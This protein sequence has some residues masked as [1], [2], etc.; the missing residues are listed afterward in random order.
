MST[1]H[2]IKN[3]G[4]NSE[5]ALTISSLHE[6]EYGIN[7]VCISS[8]SLLDHTGVRSIITQNLHDDELKKIH[9][10][11]EALKAVIKGAKI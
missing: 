9:E 10:A 6:G 7:D 4:G 11:A 5:T 2:I 3:L 8:L 1:T